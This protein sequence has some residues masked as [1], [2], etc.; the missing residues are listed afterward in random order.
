[1]AGG[2]QRSNDHP[3]NGFRDSVSDVKFQPSQ[4]NM[5]PDMLA[6]ASWDNSVRLFSVQRNQQSIRCTDTPYDQLDNISQAQSRLR[7]GV[8]SDIV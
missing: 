6:C 2:A 3:I 4:N 1:M 5:Q 8:I 7:L